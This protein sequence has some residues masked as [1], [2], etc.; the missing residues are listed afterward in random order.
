LDALAEL[1]VARARL[2]E[3][4][5]PFGAGVPVQGVQ[6]K[7]LDLIGCRWHVGPCV[8]FGGEGRRSARSLGTSALAAHGGAPSTMRQIPSKRLNAAA[9][10]HHAG[11]SPSPPMAQRS[12]ARA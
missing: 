4:G 5:G 6:E 8:G 9:T 2:I 3:E 10:N 1:S 12:Q 11:A 7:G